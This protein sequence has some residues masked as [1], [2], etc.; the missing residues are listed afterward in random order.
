VVARPII[1]SNDLS[2]VLF[3]SSSLTARD[4]KGVK[5]T[6]SRIRTDLTYRSKFR[7]GK[8]RVSIGSESEF[9]LIWPFRDS[10]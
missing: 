2:A 7:S 5:S 1:T 8:V 3:F 9:A 6:E 10:S 4:G